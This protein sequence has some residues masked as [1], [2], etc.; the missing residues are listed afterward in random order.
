MH[1]QLYIIECSLV[2]KSRE[3]IE[4]N[5]FI[6]SVEMHRLSYEFQ[7]YSIGVLLCISLSALQ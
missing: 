3:V 7:A 6:S 5:M 4:T 1:V 2:P